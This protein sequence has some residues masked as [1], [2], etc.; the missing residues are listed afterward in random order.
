VEI[1]LTPHRDDGISLGMLGYV[2]LEVRT[3]SLLSGVDAER[4]MDISVVLA[5]GK[6]PALYGHA[7]FSANIRA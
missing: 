3:R 1:H 5:P 7:M 6:P 2:G 4:P